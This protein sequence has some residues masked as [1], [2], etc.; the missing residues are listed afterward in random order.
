MNSSN[1]KNE[2]WL[3]GLAFLVAAGFRMIQLGASPLTDSEAA[4]AMQ[5]LAIARGTSPLLDPQPAYILLTGVLFA[6]TEGTNFLAR[7]VPALAGSALV[8]LPFFF[9][10]KLK[11]RAALILAFFIAFDPG[12]VALSRQAHGTILAVTALLFTWAMWRQG[13][14]IPAGIAAGLALLSGPSIWS[15]LLTL[16]LTWLFLKG[17]DSKQSA[18]QSP[19]SGPDVSE[20]TARSSTTAEPPILDSQASTLPSS[21]TDSQSS[22]ISL[23]PFFTSLLATLLL[24]GTLFFIVPNGLSA[25]LSSIPAYV[26]GW[27]TAS[28]ATPGRIFFTFISYEPLGIFLAGLAVIRGVRTKS[29]RITRLVLWLGVSLLLAVFYRQP[30]ELAWVIIPLLVL[31]ALELSNALNVHGNERTEAGLVALAAVILMVFVWFN[32]AGIAL[33]PYAQVSTTVPFFGELQNPRTL[34][35]IGSFALIAVFGALVAFGWSAH[36]ARIGITWSFAACI[37]VYSLGAAW[38]ASGLRNPGGVELWTTDL[39]PLH[40]DLLIASVEEVSEFSLGHALS[41]PVTLTGIDS[42]ALEWTLRNHPLEIVS[43]LDPQAAPPLLI[44]PIM[45]DP[46]LPSAYRGQDFTWR[47]RPQWEILQGAD[48]LKWIVYRQLPMD[49]ETV[50]LWARDDLFPDAREGIQP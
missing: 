17:M 6:I 25:W 18:G 5:S 15:G 8:F 9:R 47:Q 41:Q 36:I 49:N 11:P 10:D 29:K 19:G 32:I 33:D 31:S 30:A 12:L 16:G 48:W 3:Y 46:G 4:L 21:D 50:I 20:S 2:G 40:A 24:V 23:R 28:A 1:I 22:F 43:T 37:G 27:V 38:G 34:V 7:F 45:D 13:R 39:K 26:M 35:L 14:L 42:P 44:T